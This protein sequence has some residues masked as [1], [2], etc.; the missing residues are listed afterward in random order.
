MELHM[1]LH[2]WEQ[3]EPDWWAAAVSGFAAGFAVSDFGLG[4]VV[5]AAG[6]AVDGFCACDCDCCC[7]CTIGAQASVATSA[8]STRIRR[9]I[10]SLVAEYAKP[11]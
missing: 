9:V 11:Q 6:L 4:L 10:A 3:R 8:Q 2:R 1:H 5:V 7:A